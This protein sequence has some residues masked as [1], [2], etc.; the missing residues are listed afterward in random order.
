VAVKKTVLLKVLALTVLLVALMAGSAAAGSIPKP[1]FDPQAT[2]KAGP[3]P[4]EIT[5][6]DFD[7]DGSLDLVTANRFEDGTPDNGDGDISLL[8]GNSDGTFDEPK[9]F[10]V[11]VSALDLVAADFN[12]DKHRDLAVTDDDTTPASVVILLGDGNGDLK[13]SDTVDSGGDLPFEIIAGNFDGDNDEDLAVTNTL[14]NN[15]TILKN[16]GNGEFTQGPPTNTGTDTSPRSLASGDFDKDGDLDLAVANAGTNDV[17]ILENQNGI[18]TPQTTTEPV[19]N[20]PV[21]IVVSDFNVDG[22]LDFATANAGSDDVSIRLQSKG[23]G[24]RAPGDDGNFPSGGKTPFALVSA[25]F[26]NDRKKDI[27]VAN[28]FDDDADADLGNF[29]VLSGRGDGNF[30]AAQAFDMGDGPAGITHGKFNR[31]NEFDLAT[32]NFGDDDA[33]TVDSV[34]VRINSR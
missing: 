11:S 31:D 15:V 22:R 24:F 30:K 32:A 34:S 5:N 7:E 14:S 17:V 23:G 8:F 10:D 26:N 16:V 18:F 19:G 21:D 6:G 12:G 20:S 25:D 27:A 3:G 28:N 4:I 13:K 29:G 33:Q 9:Q 2:Y 1:K